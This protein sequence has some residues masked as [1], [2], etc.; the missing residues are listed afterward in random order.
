MS[1]FLRTDI[2]IG[3]GLSDYEVEIEVEYTVHRGCAQT[4]TQPGEDDS[5]EILRITVIDDTG[6]RHNADWLVP[7]MADDEE[8]VANC[9]QDAIEDQWAAE[10]YRAESR[11]E[12]RLL[13]ED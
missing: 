2:E 12:A 6:A 11:R 13:G 5:V 3:S 9:E 8:L 10:E 1:R 7:L 4:H